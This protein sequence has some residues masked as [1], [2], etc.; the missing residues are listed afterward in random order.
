VSST[1]PPSHPVPFSRQ[2]P[3]T[4]GIAGPG[5]FDERGFIGFALHPEFPEN[6]KVYNYTSEANS[7]TADF[8]TDIRPGACSITMP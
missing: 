1:A 6:G 2:S 3:G 4:L 5:S 7:G 8:T